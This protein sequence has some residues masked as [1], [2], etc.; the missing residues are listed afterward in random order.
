MTFI[1][2]MFD[3]NTPEKSLYA[4]FWYKGNGITI[5][6]M[7]PELREDSHLEFNEIDKLKEL[8]KINSD[9]HVNI[10]SEFANHHGTETFVETAERLKSTPL[11]S[12]I[13]FTEPYN[14]TEK[15]TTIYF[16]LRDRFVSCVHNYEYNEEITI[17]SINKVR[18]CKLTS[19]CSPEFE[20]MYPELRSYCAEQMFPYLI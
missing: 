3:D 9:Y 8:L 2:E 10:K 20:V 16:P 15:I 7:W 4:A 14:E 17:D 5:L 18:Y 19:E 11:V 12:T 6:E 13:M 1:E